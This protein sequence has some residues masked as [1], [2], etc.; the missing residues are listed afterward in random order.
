MSLYSDLIIK[1]GGT[2]SLLLLY[3]AVMLAAKWVNNLIAPYHIDEEIAEK[4]NTAMAVSFF[5]YLIATSIV[6]IGAL[7]GPSVD[8]YT[9]LM[10]V[11]LYSA[12]GIVL[13]NLARIIND[14]LI[15][16]KFCNVKEIIEDRNAGTGAV[17]AGSYIASGLIIAAAVHGEG[18]GIVTALAFFF[19]SQLCLI[20]FTHVYNLI[21]P[22]DIHQQIED[23]NVAAG[24]AFAGTLV[25][26]GIILA[27][28]TAGNF[29][30]W[31]TNLG[32][33][34]IN[35]V[36]AVLILPLIRLFLDKAILRSIDLNH[37]I[38]ND[39]NISSGV[40]EFAVTVSFAAVLYFLI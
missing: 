32:F 22:Y 25:A 17:Q 15:L 27:K 29:I 37:A 13:L 12:L 31:Q 24:I 21:T 6:F 40:L 1:A 26:V 10:N 39:R 36:I 30:D 33:F 3:L 18:G 4:H 16:Y 8:F 14:R 20:I 35:A 28:A 19:L 9:D 11:G 34:A 5:G 2:L 7:L 38:E 23:D